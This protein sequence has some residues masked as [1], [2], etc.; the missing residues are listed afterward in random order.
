[1]G[2]VIGPVVVACVFVLGALL[3]RYIGRAAAR[4]TLGPNQ[5]AGM[6]TSATMS[7]PEAWRAGHRAAQ[8]WTDV[9]TVVGIVV[10]VVGGVLGV[11]GS[12]G[13]AAGLILAAALVLLA[14]TIGG[15]VVAHRAAKA[16]RDRA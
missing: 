8:G 7:S 15:G 16:V 3:V 13:W 1:M 10:A 9:A 5:V 12:D 4:G 6:R 11:A 14:G 2:E